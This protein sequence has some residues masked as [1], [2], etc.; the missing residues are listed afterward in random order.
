MFGRNCVFGV[1][2][3]FVCFAAAAAA[4]L[5]DRQEYVERLGDLLRAGQMEQGERRVNAVQEARQAFMRFADDHPRS[6]YADDSRFVYSVIE[7]MGAALVPPRDMDTAR[8]MIMMMDRTLERYPDG[9]LE[10]ETY[11]ILERELGQEGLA[12]VFYMPYGC[13][14]EYMQALTCSATRDHRSAI[15]RYN[16][17]KRCL[18]PIVDERVAAEVYIPLY[19]AYLSSERSADAQAVADEAARLFPGSE[20][21]KILGTVLKEK[22]N[23]P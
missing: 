13:V 23:R 7:F 22:E 6:V 2:C 17:L 8:Q 4:V 1:L 11:S 9:R 12:G 14:V 10:P 20:L 21:E 16:R 5:S 19:H 18:A 3:S 15:E